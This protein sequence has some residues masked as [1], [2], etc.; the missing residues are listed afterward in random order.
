MVKKEQPYF[1]IE[2]QSYNHEVIL[3]PPAAEWLEE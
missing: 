3:Q 1:E 2:N